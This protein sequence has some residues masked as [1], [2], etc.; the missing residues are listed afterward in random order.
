MFS[1]VTLTTKNLIAVHCL[2]YTA[3]AQAVFIKA[4]DGRKVIFHTN[5]SE[6]VFLFMF[7]KISPFYTLAKLP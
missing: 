7:T 2:V 4:S 1:I 3:T 5:S 6:F